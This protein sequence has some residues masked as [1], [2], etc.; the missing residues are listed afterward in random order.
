MSVPVKLRSKPPAKLVPVQFKHFYRF[1]EDCD[2]LI[3]H[4]N[5]LRE[6]RWNVHV[7]TEEIEAVQRQHDRYEELIRDCRENLR[8]YDRDGDDDPR[9]EDDVDLKFE[10]VE[11]RIGMMLA[12]WSNANFASKDAAEVFV[13]TMVQHVCAREPTA[14]EL[15]SCCRKLIDE[16]KPYI[17][18]TPEVIKALKAEQEVWER[19][20]LA[21]RCVDMLSR[22][23]AEILPKEIA[24]REAEA[25]AAEARLEARRKEDREAWQKH[26][27]AAAAAAAAAAGAAAAAAA[28][29]EE[30]RKRGRIQ[31]AYLCGL[32]YLMRGRPRLEI[33]LAGAPK[34]FR[35][36]G[37]DD[38]LVAYC[39]ACFEVA[40]A[41]REDFNA[42]VRDGGYAQFLEDFH[43]MDEVAVATKR[44][45]KGWGVGR[46]S[47]TIIRRH[48]AKERVTTRMRARQMRGAAA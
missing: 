4:L 25:A 29:R 1:M 13:R 14:A 47:A 36:T 27:E 39:R 7:T 42:W 15:E 2:E 11:S 5:H 24:K 41:E 33:M 10:Y 43:I 31:N 20:K 44:L 28:A 37:R 26:Q 23:I 9:Y 12:G 30:R 16:G 18:Q 19:R 34:A 8:R 45:I 48:A 35:E 22:D 40:E 32:E 6:V 38:E 3:E 21:I 46:R 17:P